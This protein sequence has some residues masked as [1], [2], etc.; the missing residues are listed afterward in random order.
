MSNAAV[1]R[2]RSLLKT[3]ALAA[4]LIAN[5][6]LA[7]ALLSERAP[8]PAP[9][10]AFA[11]AARRG[12]ADSPRALLDRWSGLG[13][14]A[15]AARELLLAELETAALDAVA[16]PPDRYW[17]SR[18]V[19]LAEHAL[20]V[21]AARAGVRRRLD[22]L[23]GSAAAS[24][25]EFV[26]LYRP[27]DGELPFLSSAEQL[28][29]ADRRLQR[30]RER[31]AT[32]SLTS[33]ETP[34]AQPAAAPSAGASADPE[35]DAWR[36]VLPEGAAFEVA[37]RESPLAELLRTCGTALTEAE[38]RDTYALLASRSA[39]SPD[40]QAQ[41]EVRRA[42]RLRLGA[43]RFH[44][45]WSARDP[46]APA[47]ARAGR[48]A[49]LDDAAIA[50]AYAVLDDAQERLLEVADRGGGVDAAGVEAARAAAADERRELEGAVGETAAAALLAARREVYSVARMP[51]KR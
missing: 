18:N 29:V 39:A 26:R 4:S 44:R 32:R 25:P 17:Q 16:A 47:L 31:A 5:A 48:A 27:L 33:L 22:A 24:M 23:F 34:A 19:A 10:N 35:L 9:R 8:Q 51:P 20:E 49:G 3:G 43:E 14:D 13:L 12:G 46:L 50:R 28:A 45:V 2:A 40:A 30:L 38:F 36:A 15:H 1:N 42:L 21:A 6:A 37:L 11:A 41:L 7:S